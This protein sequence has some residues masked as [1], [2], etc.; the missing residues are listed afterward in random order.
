MFYAIMHYFESA[1]DPEIVT[2]LSGLQLLPLMFQNL[3]DL[4]TIIPGV[5]NLTIA[6]ML[7]AWAYQK[8]GNLYFSIGLHMGWVTVIKA[9]IVTTH[10]NEDAAASWLVG[11]TD[12]YTGWLVAAWGTLLLGIAWARGWLGKP[13]AAAR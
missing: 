12:G 4:H 7:L 13:A 3:G 5:L 9:T 8:T 10:V 1:K 6:G 2:W 11:T